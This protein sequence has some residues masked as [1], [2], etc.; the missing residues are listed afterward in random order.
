MRRDYDTY[1]KLPDGS[2]SLRASVRGHFN[3]KRKVQ[4]LMELLENEFLVIDGQATQVSSAELKRGTSR[5]S[6]RSTTNR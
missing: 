1:E 6:M 2:I 4:G 5:P 3:A